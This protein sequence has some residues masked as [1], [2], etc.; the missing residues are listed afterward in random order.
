MARY[1]FDTYH[2]T[3]DNNTV[4]NNALRNDSLHNDSLRDS[5]V[6]DTISQSEHDAAGDT[7]HVPYVDKAYFTPEEAAAYMNL[8]VSAFRIL[9][10]DP[11]LQPVRV[12]DT[13]LYRVADV[14]RFVLRMDAENRE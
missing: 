13:Y 8:S 11:D 12:R 2:N 9:A 4:D 5:A 6:P 7:S 10:A 1:E 3:V 14:Q